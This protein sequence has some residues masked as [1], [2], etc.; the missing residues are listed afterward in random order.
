MNSPTI[1]FRLPPALKERL[2]AH[3]ASERIPVSQAL[4][5]AVERLVRARKG[6]NHER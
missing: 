5:K 4:V 6:P 3:C 1:T 2:Q